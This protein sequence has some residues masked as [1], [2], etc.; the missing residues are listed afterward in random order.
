[1]PSRAAFLDAEVDGLH[2]ELVG[3]LLDDAF[4]REIGHWRAGGAIG[5]LL[6]TVGDDIEAH[7]PHVLEIVLGKKA[8]I[9]PNSTGEPAKAPP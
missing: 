2:P 5:R 1:M 9:A 3:H 4:D 7:R 6:G 8:V